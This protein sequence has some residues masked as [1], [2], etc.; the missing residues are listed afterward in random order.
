MPSLKSLSY[1]TKISNFF[2]FADA[3]YRQMRKKLAIFFCIPLF[4]CSCNG[5]KG[6]FN[7]NHSLVDEILSDKQSAELSLI[8][9]FNPELSDADIC[10]FGEPDRV[11]AFADKFATDD[12]RDNITGKLRRDSIP[13]F[14]GETFACILDSANLGYGECFAS[15]NT[16][17]LGEIT[18]RCGL[19]ALDT[20]CHVSNYDDKG[21]SRKRTAKV[22]VVAS[23]YLSAF[24]EPSLD[25]LMSRG[26]ASI[27]VMGTFD[28]MCDRLFRTRKGSLNVGVITSREY[29]DKGI[30]EK[31]YQEYARKYSKTD[32]SIC[33]FECFDRK[34]PLKEFI[35]HYTQSGGSHPLDA[36][37]IDDYSIEVPLMNRSYKRLTSV[38]S[39]ESVKYG[40]YLANGFEIYDG[41]STVVQRCYRYLRDND[42]F[43]FAISYPVVD[44]YHT[45][46]RPVLTAG[47]HDF[48]LTRDTQNVQK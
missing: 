40:K 35:V 13:D 30:Y 15:G 12:F 17:R 43:T 46:R 10:I 26:G 48:M 39:G 33:E 5:I 31:I 45:V 34:D 16:E 3:F 32:C 14:S 29:V 1:F 24:G 19:M 8:Q 9:G 38:M 2:T 27:P 47:A 44:Y 25:T 22:I 36:I 6:V 28:S 7:K 4:L 20:V 21:L 42:L 18:I 23:P 37:L 41:E 11:K